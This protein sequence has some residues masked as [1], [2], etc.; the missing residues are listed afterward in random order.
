MVA[1]EHECRCR[2]VAQKLYDRKQICSNR[3]PVQNRA[4]LQV[5]RDF[6]APQ[7]QQQRCQ[8][9]QNGWR[10]RGDYESRACHGLHVLN[11]QGTH[12]RP[13]ANCRVEESKPR[14]RQQVAELRLRPK[15]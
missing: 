4:S 5:G 1:I 9:D 15:R 3:D 6:H 2:A 13:D 11:V 14:K 8:T 10:H 12:L 7:A